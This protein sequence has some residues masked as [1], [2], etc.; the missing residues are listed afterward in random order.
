M[1]T[2]PSTSGVAATSRTYSHSTSD[3]LVSNKS[4]FEENF[5]SSA[6]VVDTAR[7][8]IEQ[9]TVRLTKAMRPTGVQPDE[10]GDVVALSFPTRDEE[11]QY[12]AATAQAL[13][14]VAFKE[15]DTERGLSWSD[16]AVL[17]RSV[18]AS[19]APITAALQTAGIPFLVTGMTNLFETLEAEAARQLFYFIGDRSGVD[20]A[21]IEQA[22]KAANLGLVPDALQSAIKAAAEARAALNDPEQKRWGQYS[23]QRVFLN[24]LEE[25]GVRE[26][27]VPGDRAEVVFYNL[28]KFSQL[29]SD[30]EA[31][32][33]HSKPV[34][35]YVSFADF[36]QFRA[37]DAYP[38]RITS[39]PVQMPCGL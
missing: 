24:F 35:K 16:M 3:T 6:G 30:F 17:L 19:A 18:K 14:G 15:D 39:M 23:I 8:F 33:F 21:A 7:A 2:R 5:R 31:I 27:Y 26:E 25:A 28:G 4:L 13:R 1:T 10:P 29:I 11:A 36:L 32:H 37:E 38:G 20:E 12:I 9:N 34:E 22:W